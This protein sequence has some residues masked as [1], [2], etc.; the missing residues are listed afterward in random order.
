M[1]IGWIVLRPAAPGLFKRECLQTTRS[2]R[3][4]APFY[5]IDSAGKRELTFV[6]GLSGKASKY[7]GSFRRL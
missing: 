3:A 1:G 6:A 4:V 5:S 7:I 2:K